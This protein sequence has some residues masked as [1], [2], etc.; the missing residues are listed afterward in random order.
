M[1]VRR[2]LMSGL[3]VS[4]P[5]GDQDDALLGTDRPARLTPKSRRHTVR[6]PMNTLT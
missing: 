3:G 1:A 5:G 4:V 2:Q 6:R